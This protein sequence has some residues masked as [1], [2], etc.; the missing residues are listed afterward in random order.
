MEGMPK[1]LW[2]DFHSTCPTPAMVSLIICCCCCCCWPG[3]LC[4]WY[5]SARTCWPNSRKTHAF[6]FG[7]VLNWFRFRLHSELRIRL[8]GCSLLHSRDWRRR[9]RLLTVNDFSVVFLNNKIF[10]ISIWKPKKKLR[11]HRRQKQSMEQVL[12]TWPKRSCITYRSQ[13][14]PTKS[15]RIFGHQPHISSMSLIFDQCPT[16]SWPIHPLGLRFTFFSRCFIN[17]YH[18]FDYLAWSMFPTLIAPL[19]VYRIVVWSAVFINELFA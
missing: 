12:L 17:N 8:G 10:R 1:R 11:R 2:V 3:Q 15:S 5:F 13:T 4:L 19:F 9:P 14:E 16:F 18:K 6:W 7:V